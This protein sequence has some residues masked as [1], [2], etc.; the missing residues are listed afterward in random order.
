MPG[1]NETG[2]PNTLDY[3]LGKGKIYFGKNNPSTGL[4]DVDGLRDLGNTPAMTVSV[5]VERRDHRNSRDCLAFVDAT[6]ITSQ[7]MN[8]SFQ[9][10]EINFENLSDYLS[11]AVDTV[12]NPHDVTF[13]DAVITADV[14]LGRWYELRNATGVRVYNIDAVGVVYTIEKDG[15]PDVLLVEGTDYE[16]DEQ[17]GMVFFKTTAVNIAALDQ[18]VWSISTGATTPQD[19]DRVRALQRAL[20]EG[21]LVF[22]Q[23]NAN[24]CGQ[25]QLFR[26]HRAQLTGDGEL[27]LIGE[28][29]SVMSFSG[30][31]GINSFVDATSPVEVL[32]YGML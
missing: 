21:T 8:L 1:F 5:E 13:V 16:I 24:N 27:P 15:A 19:L 14:K 7:T 22:I 12:N 23:D 30:I 4:V 32:T 17:L 28:E 31:A 11:G 2:L 25:R 18:A 6:F 29:E 9:L 26:F 10:D 20:V 3:V